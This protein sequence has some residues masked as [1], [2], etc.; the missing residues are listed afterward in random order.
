MSN[1]RHFCIFTVRKTKQFIQKKKLILVHPAYKTS[2][3]LINQSWARE[4]KRWSDLVFFHLMW[5]FSRMFGKK[6]EFVPQVLKQVVKLSCLTV[7]G[8]RGC[9]EAVIKNDDLNAP[10][11][12]PECP[13][14]SI[15]CIFCQCPQCR[16]NL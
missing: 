12:P 10:P 16:A 13:S 5:R 14:L 3:M 7:D 2:N 4:N 11:P 6:Q 8:F 15:S 9:F 1:D